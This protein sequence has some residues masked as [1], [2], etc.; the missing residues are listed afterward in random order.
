MAGATSW[1]AHADVVRRVGAQVAVDAAQVPASR[2]CLDGGFAAG[3][4]RLADAVDDAAL[5]APPVQHGGGALQH[6]DA[7]DVVQIA[8]VL[9]V[10]A[11]AIQI[12]VVAGVEA[13]DAHRVE[14]RVLRA[15]YVCTFSTL[16]V[17]MVWGT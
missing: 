13:A 11:D 16:T 9:A 4:W 12:E 2:L 5:A 3:L 15:G 14:T 17:S 6:F 7:F 1:R 10:V 8:H